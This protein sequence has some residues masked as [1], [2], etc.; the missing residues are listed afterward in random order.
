MEWLY[1]FRYL[2][3]NEDFSIVST[4]LQ[5]GTSTYDVHTNNNL[6]GVQIGNRVRQS[7]GRWSLEGTGKAGIF[8][9]AAEQHSDPII[10]FPAF[11]VRPGTFGERRERG[12]RRR[13]QSD[14]DLS[15]QSRVGRSHRLQPD[16][17]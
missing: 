17:D 13:P 4:D 5:E 14:G 2:N 15:D 7:R 3:L 1:G 11:V 12:I 8:G 10:D 9:N 6:F 16:L